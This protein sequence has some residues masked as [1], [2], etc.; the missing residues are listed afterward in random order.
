MEKNLFLIARH[1]RTHL[2]D[3]HEYVSHSEAS[4]DDEGK[5]QANEAA[6]FLFH[7]PDKIKHVFVS[8]LTRAQ[9]TAT[10]ICK[11]LGIE[12]YYIDDRLA[13]LDV[14]DFTGKSEYENPID[15]Y[16]KDTSK[17]FP[18]GESI[19][20]FDARQIDFG[21][22]LV[23]QIESGLEAGSI[24]IVAHAPNIAFWNNIQNPDKQ[25]AKEEELVRSGGIVLVTDEELFPLLGKNP[26]P[27]EKQDDKMDPAVVLYMPPEA[28]GKDG[29]SCGTCVLGRSDG[30][31]ISVHADDD[32]SD[33]KINLE[34]GVCGIYVKGKLD[35]LIQIQ[36]AV[37]RTV[38]G[39]IEK[40]APT[41]C[42]KCEYFTHHKEYGCT[43]VDGRKT[44]KGYIEAGG[45]C[46]RWESLDKKKS[47]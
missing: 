30:H 38:A 15:E 1:G 44:A 23:E 41:N 29:A 7:W 37:S 47:S 40:G 21:N 20:D 27:E 9:E 14:G 36:P 39:Y 42:G 2:N 6:E 10:I 18:N 8:P 22:Y 32:E 12:E 43:K 25:I 19:D 24:L 13:D 11:K 33:T 16:L 17:K 3:L 31:C 26:T 34:T 45:C 5:K 4:L 46:N 35:S 28:L